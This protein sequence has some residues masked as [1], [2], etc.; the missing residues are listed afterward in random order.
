MTVLT[1][2]QQPI[3]IQNSFGDNTICP[4]ELTRDF[5]ARVTAKEGFSIDLIIHSNPVEIYQ[6]FVTSLIGNI[7]NQ[8]CFSTSERALLNKKIYF[9]L[10][11]TKAKLLLEGTFFTIIVTYL[12]QLY[13]S[14][15]AKKYLAKQFYPFQTWDQSAAAP[16][17][18]WICIST[19]GK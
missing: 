9:R 1:F 6:F 14:K 8:F 12:K 17:P 10:N 13:R 3:A 7:L 16:W 5:I 4:C 15:M 18:F 2:N 11:H 19:S